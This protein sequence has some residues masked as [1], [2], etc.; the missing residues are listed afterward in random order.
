MRRIEFSV[1]REYDG[2][3]LRG[4]LRS[5]IGLSSRQT[6]RLKR[7]PGGITRD[8]APITAPDLLHAGDTV[9]LVFQDDV[10]LPPP[11]PLPVPVLYQDADLLVVDKPASM[12]MYPCPG[13]DCDSLANAVSFLQSSA[14]ERYTFRPVYRLD[15]DTTGVVLIAKNAFAGSKL[16]GIVQKTYLAVCEGQLSG[17]GLIDRPIGLKPG[18]TIQRAV[19]PNGQRAVTRWRALLT[20]DELSFVA[21]RLKTG[22]THQIR[23]HF[24]DAGHP[25]A[26]DDMYGGSLRLIGRQALHCAEIRFCHPVT[27]K[28][29]RFVAPLPDDMRSLLNDT[30]IL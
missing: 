12:P 1:P 28:R 16:A 7:Q 26:G 10:L 4:F 5:Y 23:V 21:I 30:E 27:G 3:T 25:L 22:R 11:R 6:A 2:V 8:G 20:G 9:S 24:S 18:H 17:S 19:A 13:H 15:R 14:G 29:I